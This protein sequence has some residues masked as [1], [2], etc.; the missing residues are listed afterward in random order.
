LL[1]VYA[2]TQQLRAFR[3]GLEAISLGGFDAVCAE[4]D[5]APAVDPK[6]L[7]AFD[8]SV[9]ELL[10]SAR[11]LIPARFASTVRDRE[12][13]AGAVEEARDALERAL[14]LVRDRVQMTLRLSGSTGRKP[15][16]AAPVPK[17]GREY[18][19]QRLRVHRESRM[20]PEL[21]P[22]R[23]WL[24]HLVVAERTERHETGPWIA[25]AYHLVN[26]NRVEDYRAVVRA[27][28]PRLEVEVAIS[29]PWAPYAFAPGVLG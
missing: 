26:K 10:G 17:T 28:S 25:S 3:S 19:E 7:V 16:E 4:V 13:L 27:F 5:R 8:R 15:A 9:T 21:D 2:F 14:A 12:E 18:L 23:A 24:D 20:V 22:I 6:E 11:A 1:L 29:G